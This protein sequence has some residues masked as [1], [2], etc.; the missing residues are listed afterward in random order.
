MSKIVLTHNEFKTQSLELSPKARIV[1]NAAKKIFLAHGFSGAT[2]DMIQ[3]EAGVSKSTVYAHFKNKETL[4]SA[5]VEAECTSN[6]S[7]LKTIQFIPGK[8]RNVLLE[9][10]QTY[11]DVVL[12]PSGASLSR[13]VIAEAERFPQLGDIFY[14]AGPQQSIDLVSQLIELAIDHKDIDGRG[15]SADELAKLFIATVR[16]E[17]QLYY[18]THPNDVPSK[19]RRKEWADLVVDGFLMA[20][21]GKPR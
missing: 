11:L 5:V 7:S 14:R 10:A 17:P 4:F 16:S 18:L 3:R 20:F 15:K 21:E 8:I 19:K 6:S 12:A 1:L 13:I 9:V 2:T